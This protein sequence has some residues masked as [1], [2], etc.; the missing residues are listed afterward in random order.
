MAVGP[1]NFRKAHRGLARQLNESDLP[2][3]ERFFG[4]RAK[5]LRLPLWLKG[6]RAFFGVF[7]GDELVSVGSSMVNLPEIWTLVSIETH[8]THRG[9]GLATEV[10]SSLVERAFQETQTVSL[11]VVCDNVPAI[12]VYEKLGFEKIDRCVWADCGAGVKP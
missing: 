4:E 12:R 10:T 1:G 7:D 2:A 9:K 8:E 3:L 11:S 6:A 5:K